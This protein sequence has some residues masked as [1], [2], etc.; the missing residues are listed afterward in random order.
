LPK[1]NRPTRSAIAAAGIIPLD[2]VE[3]MHIQMALEYTE[4]NARHAAEILGIHRNTLARKVKNYAAKHPT[5]PPTTLRTPPSQPDNAVSP[6]HAV[7]VDDGINFGNRDLQ[8]IDYKLTVPRDP[9][10]ARFS[11]L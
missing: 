11:S 6:T 10:P 8:P 5:I 2:E 3:M 9:Q 4:G 1:K 7:A